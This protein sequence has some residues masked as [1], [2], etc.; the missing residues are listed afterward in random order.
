MAA[1]NAGGRVVQVAADPAR[2]PE[3]ASRLGAYLRAV[4]REHGTGEVTLR[5]RREGRGLRVWLEGADSGRLTVQGSQVKARPVG[6]RRWEAYVA[7][8]AAGVLR[9]R[10][11]GAEIIVPAAMSRELEGLASDREVAAGI[12][13]R[14]GGVLYALGER[15]QQRADEKRPGVLLLLLVGAA[16]VLISAAWRRKA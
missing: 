8:V 10:A 7:Q 9:V 3:L 5:A 12:A 4:L 11:A 6:P 16:L 15:P 14:T 1:W 2:N 13:N